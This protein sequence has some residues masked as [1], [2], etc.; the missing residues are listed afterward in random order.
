MSKKTLFRYAPWLGMGLGWT[1]GGA[2]GAVL[3]NVVGVAVMKLKLY[4]NENEQFESEVGDFGVAFI[5][6]AAGVI[7]ADRK[8]YK[9]EIALVKEML[10]K[11]YGYEMGGKGASLLTSILK[12]KIDLNKAC[13]QIKANMSYPEKLNMLYFL[14]RLA[15]RDKKIDPR[16]VDVLSL[17]STAIGIRSTDYSSIKAMFVKEKK[18]TYSQQRTSSGKGEQQRQKSEEKSSRRARVTY[19]Y[20]AYA[21]LGLTESATA[22]EVKIA[23]RKLAVKH[24]PDKVAHLSE[25]HRKAAKE[26]FQKINSAYQYIKRKKGMH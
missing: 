23:F 11:Q 18:T 14:F 12:E 5:V 26:K 17:I 20:N 10:V 1:L 13:K 3:G 25:A 8:I 4:I 6:L 19:V 7:K 15:A 21:V 2:I 16:E 24:H 9:V 22:D